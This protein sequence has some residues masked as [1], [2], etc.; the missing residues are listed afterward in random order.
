MYDLISKDLTEE[1]IKNKEDTYARTIAD[2]GIV[3]N[4]LAFDLWTDPQR[5]AQETEI[6]SKYANVDS[7]DYDDYF[8]NDSV[9]IR[10][11]EPVCSQE[12]YTV[13]DGVIQEVLTN[14]NVD[15]DKLVATANNDFQANHLDN[16]E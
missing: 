2:G 13:L 8:N 9:T 15:I 10:P 4:R 11:E 3:L 6:S 5:M 1:Q 7:K 14:K 12:L 16:L